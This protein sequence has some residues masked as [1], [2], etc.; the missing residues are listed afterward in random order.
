MPLEQRDH[1]GHQWTTED[2][3]PIGDQP[4]A[5]LEDPDD[6]DPD[7]VLEEARAVT[8]P[9]G[10]LVTDGG[11]DVESIDTRE[12]IHTGVSITAKIKRGS[13]TRDQDEINIKAKGRDAEHA[14]AQM[15]RV[16]ERAEE[17]S[18]QLREVQPDA[19]DAGVFE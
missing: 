9:V 16:L 3:E 11:E 17:W 2:E 5:V 12:Q 14:A 4:P 19:G 13:G 7:D 15:D 1:R 10:Q 18:E 6:R 8:A